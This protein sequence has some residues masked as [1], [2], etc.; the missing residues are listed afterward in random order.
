MPMVDL[1]WEDKN[2]EINLNLI[3]GLTPKE[4]TELHGVL[5]PNESIDPKTRIGPEGMLQKQIDHIS[6]T[7]GSTEGELDRIP[8]SRARRGLEE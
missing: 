4:T 1:E 2:G 3:S 5:L 8:D 7:I 6:E